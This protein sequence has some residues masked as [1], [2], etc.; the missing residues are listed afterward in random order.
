MIDQTTLPLLT[1]QLVEKNQQNIEFSRKLLKSAKSWKPSSVKHST[2]LSTPTDIILE[3]VPYSS[4]SYLFPSSLLSSLL[5]SS[6]PLYSSLPTYS[7]LPLFP[8]YSFPPSSSLFLPISLPIFL[9]IPPFSSSLSALPFLSIAH[10]L[11]LFLPFP[12]PCFIL[13]IGFSF[14][15]FLFLPLSLL[16]LSIP[17]YLPSSPSFPLYLILPLF[18]FLPSSPSYPLYLILLS[19]FT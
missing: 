15:F 4:L 18:P 6:L 3:K 14:L 8:P 2:I 19:G 5:P 7:S 9:P 13:L 16:L 1:L 11:L 12:F 17:S 10:S